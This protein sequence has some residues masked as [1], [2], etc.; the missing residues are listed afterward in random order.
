MI[1]SME[2]EAYQRAKAHVQEV[3][4]FYSHLGVYVL[5]NLLLFA[6]NAVTSW[7]NW[8]F[9]WVTFFW[10]IGIVIHAASVWGGEHFFGKE[11]EE[12]KIQKILEKENR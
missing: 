8:W 1:K 2:D 7:G 12:K 11:W 9:Y 10:G 4:G 5:I 3:K 6:V